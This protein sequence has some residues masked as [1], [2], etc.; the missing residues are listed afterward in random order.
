MKEAVGA[1]D[2]FCGQYMK[3]LLNHIGLSPHRRKRLEKMRFHNLRIV[4][5][6][7]AMS[8]ISIFS[9]A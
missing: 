6:E 5:D 9:M 7:S 1:F 2:S 4:A 8:S 3:Q